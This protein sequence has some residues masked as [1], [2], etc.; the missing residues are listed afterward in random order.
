M[1]MGS[2]NIGLDYVLAAGFNEWASVNRMIVLYPQ[3]ND[4]ACWDN[5]GDTGSDYAL[6]SAVEMSTVRRMVAAA[7]GNE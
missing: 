4:S 6:H 3:I 7:F 1:P 2:D 5:Y